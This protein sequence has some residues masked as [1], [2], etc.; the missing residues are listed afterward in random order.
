MTSPPSPHYTDVAARN[1]R[2]IESL[3]DGVFSIAMTLLVL[4]LRVPAA[5][6]V[7]TEAAVGPA[8]LR[9]LPDLG[10]YVLG[11]L[12][13]GIFW[14]CQS[15]QFTY[16]ERSD[17]R[18]AWWHIS[19][20][21]VVGLLPFSTAFLTTHLPLRGAVLVYW[22]NL[23]LPGLAL[24]GSYRYAQRQGLLRPAE[25]AVSRALVRRL[26]LMQLQY[27]AAVALCFVHVYAG[28]GLLLL[29]Q[30]NYAVGLVASRWLGD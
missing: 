29:V 7:R 19:F 14:V 27:A 21:L 16:L 30:L 12:S 3:S 9:L 25:A 6:L 13:L 11:F 1:L 28:V 23:L 24:L 15:T 22:A 5:A 26:G 2:R 20:L 10:G 18:L 4:N 8:L 17:R